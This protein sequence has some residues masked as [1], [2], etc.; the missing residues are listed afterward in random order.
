MR[1]MLFIVLS[2]SLFSGRFR[3]GRGVHCYRL[4]DGRES[5]QACLC[6]V[7]FGSLFSWADGK[8][9]TE[10]AMSIAANVLNG[11]NPVLQKRL[12]EDPVTHVT[13]INAENSIAICRVAEEFPRLVAARKQCPLINQF[14]TPWS[15]CDLEDVVRQK[16][17]RQK[18]AELEPC[19]L[20]YKRSIY[21]KTDTYHIRKSVQ[22]E[23]LDEI[24]KAVRR[25]TIARVGEGVKDGGVVIVLGAGW[26]VEPCTSNV[27]DNRGKAWFRAEMIATAEICALDGHPVSAFR[28]K[29][30]ELA[31]RRWGNHRSFLQESIS[32]IKALKPPRK[33][34]QI[35]SSSTSKKARLDCKQDGCA[36]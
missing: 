30:E 15:I 21:N 25:T 32:R 14:Q 8:V 24:L 29:M 16:P 5:F 1:D 18:F 34:R 27:L 10:S 20:R 9:H 28:R 33:R 13:V 2:D 6:L 35:K 3:Q 23:C 7:P 31:P 4:W 12:A 19:K 36:N 11:K 22:K 26:N 17:S